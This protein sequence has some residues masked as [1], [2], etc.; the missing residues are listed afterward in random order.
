MRSLVLAVSLAFAVAA[1]PLSAASCGLTK[2]NLA[3]LDSDVAAI[4]A[5]LP[6]DLVATVDFIVEELHDRD[7]VGALGYIVN[8]VP[9]LTGTEQLAAAQR[10]W[11]DLRRLV[12]G[13]VRAKAMNMELS[14]RFAAKRAQLKR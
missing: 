6:E 8:L 5:T 11:D 2:D 4:R 12:T 9:Q 14:T 1:V 7:Y 13:D 3:T 10:V